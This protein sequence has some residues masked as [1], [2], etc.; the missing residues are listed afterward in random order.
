M[1]DNKNEATKKNTKALV[2]VDAQIDFTTGK[3]GSDPAG[4][5]LADIM[6]YFRDMK[7]H[8]E[9][10]V[11]FDHIVATRDQHSRQ[12]YLE[13]KTIES[14]VVP[15][16]CI[17]G[18]V[19]CGIP[20]E[21]LNMATDIVTKDTFMANEDSLTHG[22]SGEWYCPEGGADEIYIC[23]FCTD[24]CVISNALLLRKLFPNSVIR[25]VKDFCCGLTPA[26]HEAALATMNSCL[27]ETVDSSFL[28]VRA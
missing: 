15:E 19:G 4:K 3:L 25:V 1:E 9:N 8:P 20:D 10:Y 16:H 12:E 5:V 7:E 22:V 6:T 24:I 13:K 27:I 17:H 26:T 18:S 11:K 28:K 14:Q 23:G 21:I 2:V